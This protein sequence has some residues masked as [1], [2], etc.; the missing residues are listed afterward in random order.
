MHHLFLHILFFK[1]HI[2]SSISFD[3]SILLFRSDQFDLKIGKRLFNEQTGKN[4]EEKGDHSITQHFLE[5]LVVCEIEV[6]FSR[7]DLVLNHLVMDQIERI[8]ELADGF[9]EGKT[10]E[11]SVRLLD[12][13]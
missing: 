3:T 12:L 13:N 7:V 1:L 8:A 4:T 2:F 6:L 10:V 5:D 9:Q 11:E